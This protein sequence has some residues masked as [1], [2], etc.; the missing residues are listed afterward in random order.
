MFFSVISLY[1][2]QFI[3]DE[4]F[5]IMFSLLLLKEE[6]IRKHSLYKNLDNKKS[7]LIL[8]YIKVYDNKRKNKT[9]NLD[10]TKKYY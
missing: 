7:I 10:E 4:D 3:Y 2:S 6:V 9:N 1:T 8:V 5:N